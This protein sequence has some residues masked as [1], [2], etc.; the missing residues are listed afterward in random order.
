MRRQTSKNVAFNML[1]VALPAIVGILAMPALLHNLGVDRLGIFTLALGLIGFA[2]IFDLGLGRALTQSVATATGLGR[3]F[4][5]IA[6]QVRRTLPVILSLGL[7]W[8]SILAFYAVSISTNLFNLDGELASEARKG[9]LWLGVAVPTMLLSGAFSGVLEG[10]Q[11]FGRVNLL[12]VP[13]GVLTFLVPAFGSYVTT[14]VGDIIALLVSVRV[15]ALSAWLWQVSRVLPL[16]RGV[17]YDEHDVVPA[18]SMWRFTGWL[19]LSNLVGP[20]MMYA[21]RFYLATVFPPS[22]IA[23]Y[24][25]PLDTLFR[26]TALPLAAMNAVFPALAH[27]GVSSDEAGRLVRGAIL[28]MS[29][30]WAIPLIVLGWVLDAVLRLWVGTEFAA[31]SLDIA[32]WLLLG[33]MVNGSAHIPYALLQSAGRADLTAKLHL[34]ELPVYVLMIVGF[35]SVFGILGA[36]LAWTGRVMLDT[37]LLYSMAFGVFQERRGEMLIGCGV[38]L[39]LAFVLFLLTI[40]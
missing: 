39:Y 24:T 25:V 6:S 36:A 7:L 22:V 37:F 27:V 2:G 17:P 38:F 31:Q 14:D 40:A 5:A 21:D 35:V 9:I 13:I 1:G 11:L 18:R 20:L 8:G 32:Q 4:G 33:V 15:I 30:S 12:R 28:L 34:L 16:R 10:L 26:A 19:S 23:Y 3:T 29:L